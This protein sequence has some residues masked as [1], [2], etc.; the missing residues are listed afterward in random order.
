MT[1]GCRQWSAFALMA[2][3]CATAAAQVPAP[4]EWRKETFE[5]PLRFAPSIPYEGKEH[6]AFAPGWDKFEADTG[7]SYVILWNLKTKPFNADD[8]EDYLETYF[9]GLMTNVGRAREL[10]PKK[11]KTSAAAHPLMGVSAWTQAFGA[12]VRTWNAFSKGEALLLWGEVT[13]RDCGARMQV[14]LAFSKSPRDHAIWDRLRAVRDATT[15]D[16]SGS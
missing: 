8:L 16:I 3:W 14:F 7:F 4:P 15:C 5:F 12:E 1:I 6:V 13:Q 11:V 9:D 10:L 2:A